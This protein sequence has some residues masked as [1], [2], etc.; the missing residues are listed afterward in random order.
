MK[1]DFPENRRG[2]T[3]EKAQMVYQLASGGAT[4]S[5]FS[6]TASVGGN[7]SFAFPRMFD[8][9]RN[10]MQG[11]TANAYGGK[12]DLLKFDEDENVRTTIL[13]ACRNIMKTHPI[14]K[15]C[16]EVYSRFPTQGLRLQHEDK[17]IERFYTELFLEDLDFE[18]FL[19]DFGKVFWTDGTAINFGNWSDSLG[20]WVGEEILD[21]LATRIERI[22]LINED[23]VY[24]VPQESLKRMIN[25]NTPEANM[26]KAAYP[27]VVD[28]II[29]GDD[30]PLSNDRVCVMANKDRP[31]DIWGTPI[32]LRA[33]NTLMLEDRM[34]SAMR[35]TADRLYAPLLLFTIGGKLPD[36]TEY[37]PPV[38]ALDSFRSN[39]DAALSSDFRAIVTHSG[40]QAQE[41]IRGDR[42]N[43]FK[44]DIDMFDERIFNAWGLPASILKNQS[45]TYASS[46]LEFQ[47]AAQMLSTYQKMLVKVY[48]K[49]AR[50]VAEAQGH[51]ETERN[52][53]QV[54]VI[55][56][57]REV[58]DPEAEDGAGAYVTKEVPKL[59]YPKMLFDV[60]NFKN[61]Q[62]E[63]KFR[64]ELRKEG[65]PIADDD[66]AI[67]VDI[68]LDSSAEKYKQEQI[69][70]KVDEAAVQDAVF[71]ATSKQGIVVPPE[72]KKYLNDG[73]MSV[74]TK[75][76]LEKYES[77][78]IVTEEEP[79]K[80]E[81]E[82]LDENAQMV[83]E[84]EDIEA[85][86][87]AK[88]FG[89]GARPEI[90]DEQRGD[91]PKP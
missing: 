67:G 47:L 65:I 3:S 35:A 12:Y 80:E 42:M 37:I 30:I 88:D 19:I 66:M 29:R 79:E 84:N 17:E 82:T 43:N 6:K 72:T 41:V 61:E 68:D 21:P 85:N 51:Y 54:K 49:Q 25:E 89:E 91:M 15:A 40:V 38:Q 44:N 81:L 18:N 55:Y 50:M 62:E 13:E 57:K 75:N 24:M 70:K 56:E 78:E 73:I 31:S 53:E 69:R 16:L 59:S 52:G 28:F 14:C 77:S 76:E 20:L 22:P 90:S 23:V 32:L 58:W 10:G 64:M 27:D 1:L 5:K 7:I 4:H 63:R 8:P 26:F 74:T 86:S 87:L 46:A 34:N 39:L 83:Q 2:I 9:A 36:G 60:V 71:R 33:W 11:Q 45:G 48:E